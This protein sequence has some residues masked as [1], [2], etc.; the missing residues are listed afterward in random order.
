MGDAPLAIDR[1]S[2]PEARF[3]HRFPSSISLGIDGF[4]TMTAEVSI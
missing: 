3:Y 2:Y 4:G 1:A